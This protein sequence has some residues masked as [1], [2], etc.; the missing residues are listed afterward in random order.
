MANKRSAH[1]GVAASSI[2]GAAAV[3]C[4]LDLD[5]FLPYRIHN[6]GARM[7]K[8][9]NTLAALIKDSGMPI[10]E[11][12]W[13]VLAVV[14]SCGGLTNSQVA[15][16]SGMDAATV[17]RAVKKL[18]QLNL[19]D[20]LSSKLDRRKA[21]IIL[22]QAGADFHDQVTPRRKITGDEI[23]A[24]MSAQEK[25]TLLHLLNK[26]DEHLG[27]LAGEDSHGNEW[28]SLPILTP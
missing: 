19:V 5:T 1:Q 14:G 13:R 24:C 25:Q 15:E 18:K 2:A 26:L 4:P 10:A 16:I 12:E 9:G 8:A 7:A 6:L 28:E 20:T 23:D 3:K 27:H 17:T 22:T 21:L 11:R